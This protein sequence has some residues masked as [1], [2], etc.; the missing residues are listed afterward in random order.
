MLC[1]LWNAY[2]SEVKEIVGTVKGIDVR[3]IQVSKECDIL[4]SLDLLYAQSVSSD[5]FNVIESILFM[6]NLCEV[7]IRL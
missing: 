5:N 2:Q 6:L 1:Y 3:K 4:M 7:T